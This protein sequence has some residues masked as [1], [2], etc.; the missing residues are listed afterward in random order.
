MWNFNTF[1]AAGSDG[2]TGGF[3][4]TPWGS[5]FGGKTIIVLTFADTFF[6]E[7]SGLPALTPTPTLDTY[8]LL[9][10]QQTNGT[11]RG[12]VSWVGPT[13]VMQARGVHQLPN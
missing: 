11:S 13:W 5:I 10:Y 2:K 9:S 4:M 8:S 3:T 1:L 12:G 7:V 6:G